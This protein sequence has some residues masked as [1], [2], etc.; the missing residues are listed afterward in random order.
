GVLRVLAVPQDP[1][2]HGEHE[3]AVAADEFPERR[4]AA[5]EEAVEQA[6][7]GLAGRVGG[8]P[9][10]AGQGRVHPLLL[11]GYCPPTARRVH[12]VGHLSVAAEVSSRHNTAKPRRYTDAAHASRTSG[13]LT[14][15][16]ASRGRPPRTAGLF[17]QLP[18]Y[19][20]SHLGPRRRAGLDTNMTA[21]ELVPGLVWAVLAHL[22]R[23]TT[24]RTGPRLAGGPVPAPPSSD[25]P[26]EGAA[27]S[28]IP[29]W[30]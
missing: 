18:A 14:P 5:G 27:H 2:T 25:G 16:R 12:R 1:V 10:Q 19:C 11:P 15:A 7:V 4:L 17:T 6:G 24:D 8:E 28:W 9:G 21:W 23:M 22:P 26:P 20:P 13:G 3:R 29:Y 30:R